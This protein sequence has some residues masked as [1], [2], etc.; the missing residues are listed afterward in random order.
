MTQVGGD[1]ERLSHIGEEPEIVARSQILQQWPN[2]RGSDDGEGIEEELNEELNHNVGTSRSSDYDY[3]YDG[4]GTSDSI[5]EHSAYEQ[6]G[7][8]VGTP[9]QVRDLL[10]RKGLFINDKDAKAI[11]A[12]LITKAQS[13]MDA[14]RGS[15][16]SAEKRFQIKE[17]IEDYYEEL[18]AT[19]IVPFMTR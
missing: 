1:S 11:G 17:G 7:I 19:F 2:L 18:E 8:M 6:K 9:Y 5:M 14:K 13:L 15:D 10:R 12:S 3:D 16:W 4:G